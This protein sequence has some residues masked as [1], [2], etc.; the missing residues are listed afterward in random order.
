MQVADDSTLY[1]CCVLVEEIIQ[2]PSGLICMISDR[3]P[4]RLS[5]SRHI[6]TTRRCYCILSR[7]PFFELHFSVLYSIFTE[8]R[9]ERLTKQIAYLDLETP[10]GYDVV[11]TLEEK[12]GGIL[13]GDGA[14]NV[15]K[16]AV[17][18]S[19]SNTNCSISGRVMDNMSQIEAV[20]DSKK[21]LNATTVAVDPETEKLASRGELVVDT[22]VVD[23]FIENQSAEKRLPNAVLPL[24]QYQQCE[25]YVSTS[26]FQG[27][28]S[29]EIHFKIESDEAHMEETSFSGQDISIE[30]SDIL[31]WAKANNHGSLQIICE[32]YELHCPARGSTVKFHPLDHL[33]PMEYHRPDETV[34]CITGSTID[35]RICNTSL[36]LVEA[37]SA[38]MAEEEAAALSV[39][40]TACLCGSLRLEHLLTLFAGA[41]LEKQIVVVCS[42]LGIL[43]A[44]V[45]SIIPLIRPYQWQSLLMPV[46]PNDMLDFLDAPVPYIVGIKSKTAELQSK[47]T[48]VILVDLNKNQVKSPAIPQLPQHREL[49]S[50][51]SPYHAK[52]VGESYLGKKRPLHE[53]TDVQVEAAKSF[54][55][56][57]RSYL[58]SVCSNLRSH[59]ITNVQSNDD[60]VSLLLKESF[61]ESFP[62]RDQPFMKLFVDTQM[63]SVHTDFVLSFFQKE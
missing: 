4:C 6:L 48:N 19:Q 8:E 10:V 51:L 50:S 45:L 7:L 25:S 41:L 9:L 59:T 24:L 57:L 63:F 14:V 60:K 11:E 30:H 58:D 12:S 34:L 44:S 52:L 47:L 18:A 37:H 54:L 53:C 20:I 35:L 3:Q 61:I 40:A 38:L 13:L 16:G 17:E 2:N 39:W 22:S 56:V 33:H 5:L 23:H 55:G 46:L 28:P 62:S 26:S 21:E 29:E 31:E 43:S 36:E 15:L 27:S 1:G 49:Y 42:N 32:Y